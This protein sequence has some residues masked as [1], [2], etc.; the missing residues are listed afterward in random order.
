MGCANLAMKWATHRGGD[1]YPWLILPH[2]PEPENA[3]PAPGAFSFSRTRRRA[4]KAHAVYLGLWP[5]KRAVPTGRE[6]SG[7]LRPVSAHWRWRNATG[8]LKGRL[9]SRDRRGPESPLQG[10]GLIPFRVPRSSFK[11]SAP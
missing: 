4:R 6:R 11:T 10:S 2:G 9:N 5:P 1:L 7:P 8:A 3:A